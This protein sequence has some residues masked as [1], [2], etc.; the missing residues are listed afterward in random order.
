MAPDK[1]EEL[2]TA[3]RRDEVILFVG[4]GANYLALL[5]WLR[6]QLG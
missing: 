1:V 6:Q 5:L 2:R 3:Y 4:D